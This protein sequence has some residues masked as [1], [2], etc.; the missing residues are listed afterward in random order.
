M[1]LLLDAMYAARI[2]AAL[3]DQGVVAEAIDGDPALLGLPDEGV[4]DRARSRGLAVVT[5]NHADFCRLGR[6]AIGSGLG[7]PGLVLVPA[8]RREV[9]WLLRE[10]VRLAGEHPGDDDLRDREVW[11]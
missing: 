1:R 8:H 7:H 2:A 11:L 10:L 3:V 9:G 6:A 4:M 5:E